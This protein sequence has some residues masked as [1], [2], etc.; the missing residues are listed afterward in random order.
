MLQVM[1]ETFSCQAVNIS[2][3]PKL[4]LY[5]VGLSES[6]FLFLF[7][8]FLSTLFCLILIF[9][10]SRKPH[11]LFFFLFFREDDGS[12]SWYWRRSL[13]N[14]THIWRI[15]LTEFNHKVFIFCFFLFSFI[16]ILFVIFFNFFVLTEWIL[17]VKI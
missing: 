8:F 7:S 6:G 17:E 11:F 12:W 5:S 14:C 15:Y 10:S 1:N 16:F 4:A 13:S 3:Q 2:K 9:V